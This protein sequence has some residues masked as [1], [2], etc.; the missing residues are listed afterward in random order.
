M[1][2][3]L[4][5]IL[6]LCLMI[7]QL[8]VSNI[9]YAN[10][11]TKEST[12]E[13]LLNIIGTDN[14]ATTLSWA[15]SVNEQGDE[16]ET[17]NIKLT[18]KGHHHL[19]INEINEKIQTKGLLTKVGENSYNLKLNDPSQPFSIKFLTTK[20]D[21][22]NYSINAQATMDNDT[23]KAS[24]IVY[25]KTDLE[26]NIVYKGIPAD[27]EGKPTMVYAVNEKNGQVIAKQ[28]FSNLTPNIIFKD[29][30]AFDDN[31]E[32]I[33]Y[34]L[35][36]D[37]LGNYETEIKGT[38]ITQTYLTTK[39]EGKIDNK[40]QEKFEI[41]VK[42]KST[43]EVVKTE[44]INGDK[45]EYVFDSLPKND[46]QGNLISYSIDVLNKDSIE[47]KIEGNNIIVKK[48]EKN[49]NNENIDN[50]SKEKN[51][52]TKKQEN[53]N[54]DNSTED[55]ST[56]KDTNTNKE[57]T[58]DDKKSVKGEKDTEVVEERSTKATEE[59]SQSIT[60]EPRSRKLFT[61]EILPMLVP[62]ATNNTFTPFSTT[63]GGQLPPNT[64]DNIVE[65][66][67]TYKGLISDMSWE[68]RGLYRNRIPQPVE[69]DEGF[70]WKTA[71]ST[72]T[73]NQ[74]SIDLKTQGRSTETTENLDIVLV[75]DNSYSMRT[76]TSSGETRWSVMKRNLNKFID[77]VTKNN[78]SSDRQVR[79]AI[80]NFAS[81][82]VS[83][84]G[85]SSNPTT[86]KNA[87]PYRYQTN[88]DYY[89]GTGHTFTQ[90]GIRTGEAVMNTSNNKKAMVVLTDGAPTFSYKITGA[91]S[92][93]NVT[94]MDYRQRVGNGAVYPLNST[95][96]RFEYYAGRTRITNH[97][98][99]TNA[100]A[101]RIKNEHPDWDIFSI[102]TEINSAS[103]FAPVEDMQAIL[104]NIASTPGNAYS[105]NNMSRDLPRI[106]SNIS[107]TTI[108]SISK[109]T[110]T[111]PIGDMY[112]IDLG[113]NGMFDDS[114]YSLT[115]S[116]PA[117][118]S[119][120]TATYDSAT[121]TIKL[122]GLTLGKGEWVNI[123]YK[124][125]LKIDASNFEDGTWYPMN[126]TTTLTPKPGS[127][128]RE[129]PV[130]EAR[131]NA[132][133]YNFTFNK[134][135]DQSSP[136][137]GAVFSLKDAKNNN[138]N[139]TSDDDGVVQFNNIAAGTYTL[140][141]ISAPSG[142]IK[143]SKEYKVVIDKS[144]KVTIDGTE[145]GAQKPFNIENTAIK[146]SLEIIKHEAD[147]KN[148][149]LPGASF[150]LTNVKDNNLSYIATSDSNGVISYEKLPLGEYKLKEIKAPSGYRLLEQ[151][152]N[153]TIT[154][155]N[156]KVIY[157][158]N[159]VKGDLLPSTGGIGRTI[160]FILGAVLMIMALI[161]LKKKSKDK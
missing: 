37:K 61:T 35:K 51:K 150:E 49:N 9:T 135:T 99:A 87:I 130:P 26:G 53:K 151:P 19:D 4:T 97:G 65:P 90:L 81:G 72:S 107:Q 152:I 50:D 46:E 7:N 140:T 133:K 112:D 1:K 47:T 160:F 139:A 69:Y 31:N 77:E 41:S 105:T 33:N 70:L 17:G 56:S 91:T 52:N 114:D 25:T 30:K 21:E 80:V 95:E 136:L 89:T 85:F 29:L 64:G 73:E 27:V 20:E 158:E 103:D 142:Y 39:L 54:E 94:S 141:E 120:V 137:K 115:A 102:G 14:D 92:T 155:A 34:I 159:S 23:A 111:D 125:K 12:D 119:D 55:K 104:K 110:V 131:Y 123:N 36:T 59:T 28:Q 79:I 118:L 100:E 154:D 106:L 57:E 66:S 144:G 149:V 101:K 44:T 38:R 93:D 145:Y 68:E 157:V 129:Y 146:G 108:K 5:T 143:S 71:Q 153:V 138:K 3:K 122:N 74:Y 13:Q 8:I 42:N 147:N 109:G 11:T 40:A 6:I 16:H 84:S 15:L 124:V 116:D 113:K 10:T 132:P 22:S 48:I 161:F 75:V 2:E 148:K 121:R 82:I 127:K 62:K 96:G 156:K 117:L 98:I 43:G 60:A 67:P 58:V 128:L 63:S 45:T 32:K 18:L 134:T 86:I 88:I 78:A 24:D 83:Q 76:Q 126:K